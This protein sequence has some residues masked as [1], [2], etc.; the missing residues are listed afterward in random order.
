MVENFHKSTILALT[1]V[2][3][4]VRPQ[5]S[6]IISSSNQNKDRNI[7]QEASCQYAAIFVC[8]LFPFCFCSRAL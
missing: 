2:E 8:R 1:M 5:L 6:L 7:L 3:K 4:L